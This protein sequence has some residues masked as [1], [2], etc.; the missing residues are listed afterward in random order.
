MRK[1]S[2]GREIGLEHVESALA[3]LGGL[4]G[5]IDVPGCRMELRGGKL[6]LIPQDAVR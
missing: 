2:A 4:Q 5:G 1:K 3:L 6:V